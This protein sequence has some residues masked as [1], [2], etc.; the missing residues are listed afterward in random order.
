MKKAIVIGATSGMG[1]GLAVRLVDEGYYVGIT[2]RRTHLLEELKNGNPDYFCLKTFDIT[3]IDNGEQHLNELVKELGDID[4]I[5]ISVGTGDINENLDYQKEK[6]AIDTNISGF[7][8]IVDWAFNYFQN[9]KSGHLVAITSIAGL[10]GS[11]QAPAYNAS[12]AYQINYLEG[13]RQK[14]KKLKLPITIT[15]IRPGFVDTDMAK[16]E[17]KFWMATVD[18]ATSQIFDAIKKKKDVVYV[19][20]RWSIIAMILKNL[21][22]KFYVRI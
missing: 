5:I 9:K 6:L 15:D 12:K 4:L 8:L 16:G 14:A 13:L 1:K 3:D 17:N 20:K 21:P 11:R 2:G 22:R 19:T 18:K 7:T 10:R